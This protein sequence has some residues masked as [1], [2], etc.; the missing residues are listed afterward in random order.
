M[1]EG[2]KKDIEIS[3]TIKKF[4]W[5]EVVK[6]TFS[7]HPLPVLSTLLQM[8]NEAARGDSSCVL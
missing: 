4:S 7:L 5:Q 8:W 6:H 2:R 3:E 1:A